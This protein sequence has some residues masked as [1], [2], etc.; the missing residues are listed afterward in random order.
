MDDLYQSSHFELHLSVDGIDDENILKAKSQERED[1]DS[2]E[3]SFLLSQLLEEDHEKKYEEKN[4]I[5]NPEEDQM[6][7]IGYRPHLALSILTWVTVVCTFGL[8][9]LLFHWRPSWKLY[10]THIKCPLDSATKVLLMDH[11]KQVFV[12][13]VITVTPED[14]NVEAITSVTSREQQHSVSR[15]KEQGPSISTLVH[16]GPQGEFIEKNTLKYFENKKL[17]YIWTQERGKFERLRGLEKNVPCSRFL[18]SKGISSK[19]QTLRRVLYGDNTIAV[20][21]DSI[22]RILF[23]E[24]LEPFY[25]F[26]VFSI[27]VWYLDD[28]PYYASC[29]IVMSL[30]SLTTGVYQIRKNQKTLYDTV[31][32]SDLVTICRGKDEYEKIPSEHLVPGDML[33][34]PRHGCV[35]QC[36]AVIITGSCLVNESMLT[37]ESVPITK[38]ALPKPVNVYGTPETLYSSKEHAR[39]SLFCG[40]KVIQTRYY[41][42]ENVT[43]LVVRTGFL[44][45]KGELVRSIM[46]P[47]PVDF[48]FNRHL[49]KFLLF[50]A[51]LASTGFIY[52]I[53]IKS[54]RGVPAGEIAL[55]ALDLITIIIPPALPAA[56]TIGIV[57]AQSRLK[58]HKIY[59][60]SPRSINLSGC[61]NCVCFDK[62]G[63]LT[64][65]GLDMWGVVPVENGSFKGVEK[66][67][68]SLKQGHLLVGMASCHSLTILDQQLIGDPLDMKMFESTNWHLEEPDI[69]D[70]TKYDIITPTI[71]KPKKPDIVQSSENVEVNPPYEIGIV[72]QL[73]FSSSLQR[74][75]VVT[76]VLGSHHFDLY[77]KGAPETIASLCDPTSVPEDFAQVLQIYT[78]QGYRVLAL[79]HHPLYKISYAKVQ[80]I[81]REELE[82]NL[83]FIGLLVMENRLK[84]ETAVNIEILKSANIRPVM[85]TGDNMLTALSVAYDCGMIVKH[86]QVV[87]LSTTEIENV[88][89]PTLSWD[90]ASLPTK[91][92]EE[93]KILRKDSVRVI[94]NDHQ[95]PH[96]VLTGK[97][98]ALLREHYPEILKKVAVCGTVFARMAPEQKQQL[99]ELL[100]ELGYYV[101]MCGDG[102]N[103]CGALKAAHTG[104]SLSEAEASVA[105]PFTSKTPDISCVPTLIREGRAALVTSFGVV[106]YMACYSMTQFSCV[107]ILYTL[108]SNMTDF[109]FL[110]V[111]LFLITLFAALFGRTEAYGSLVSKPP[112]NS[113]IS[114]VPIIS[115]FF[116]IVFVVVAQLLGTVLLWNQP[117]YVLHMP[118]DEDDLACHDNYALFAVSVF[119]YITLAVI[120]S[121]GKPYRKPFIT[122]SLFLG[123]LII[124]ALFSIYLVVYPS[125]WLAQLFEFQLEGT[126]VEFRSSVV[127]IAFGHFFIAYITETYI[128][129]YLVFR[130]CHGKLKCGKQDTAQYKNIEYETRDSPDWLPLSG[131]TTETSLTTVQTVDSL[132]FN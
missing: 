47:K 120:F 22:L 132:N 51:G 17:R 108:K 128:I 55:R 5:N 89:V 107:I 91:K 119:Q 83:T 94:I 57:F 103:D 110:Y 116:Q 7:I 49:G 123:A 56:M 79:A 76:R 31:Y 8:L 114:F 53:I 118:E 93:N 73:P 3:F 34:I 20:S 84:P 111:D 125:P 126:T 59:C 50:M 48:K 33:V 44:T 41:G 69:D 104:I 90:F 2:N 14:V 37:G 40:T 97:T 24:V 87:H 131:S 45:A 113:L 36:D 9:R 82:V 54:A 106:K 95:K 13:D 29:I 102:A 64:E 63:T 67:P 74:M 58:K 62:T 129:G 61:I 28:Y 66:K 77:T 80:R 39:H 26:Q 11:Y 96:I 130:R 60:I 101:G 52:T 109:E 105:S 124:M 43:A 46:F 78:Q 112:P 68:S 92:S 38:T 72:R 71:V 27:I 6:D 65:D 88:N 10:C 117:W 21:V 19:D 42:K 15:G 121:A 86:D 99:V 25:V 98:F 70:T 23:S 12:E 115:L 4:C 127:A 1:K 122:N 18:D 75:S 32:G 30:L 100:Q 81:P 16:L 85:I 35:M